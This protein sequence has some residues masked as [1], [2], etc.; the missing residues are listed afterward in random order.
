MICPPDLS[1]GRLLWITG[2]P[3]AGKST[4]AQ[5]LGR[6]HDFVY[7]DADCFLG[8]RNPFIP[9]DVG[10]PTMA[11]GRQRPLVGEG[12]LERKENCKEI[13]TALERFVEGEETSANWSV[14]EKYLDILCAD[15]RAQRERIGGNWAVAGCITHRRMR[16]IVRSVDSVIMSYQSDI[17]ECHNVI[18]E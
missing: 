3:G 1:Q 15:I 13:Q 4:S 8:L 11:Q 16:D 10:N 5:L 2:P 18:S 17:S 12:S 7:Y 6:H 14:I 9:R